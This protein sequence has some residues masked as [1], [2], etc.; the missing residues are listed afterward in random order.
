M[1][2][3]GNKIVRKFSSKPNPFNSALTKLNV[4]GQSYQYYSLSALNDKRLGKKKVYF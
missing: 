4:D 2:K 1:F 3:Q